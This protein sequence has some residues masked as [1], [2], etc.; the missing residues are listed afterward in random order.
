MVIG[1]V[2]SSGAGLTEVLTFLRG[3]SYV[4]PPSNRA[5]EPYI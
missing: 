1:T 3:D 4:I 5:T 2:L